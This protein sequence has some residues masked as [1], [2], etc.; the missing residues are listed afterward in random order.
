MKIWLLTSELPHEVTGGIA[1]YIDNYARLL[2]LSGHE[3]L[4]IAQSNEVKDIFMAPQVRLITLPKSAKY[5]AIMADEISF[6]YQFA[7]HIL[8]L[9]QTW[10]QPDIIES[11]EYLAL[12]YYL[13]QRKLTEST[14]LT[15]IPILLHLHT[16]YFIAAQ[17][18]QEP[19]YR[20]PYYWLG[21]MEKFC[22]QAADGLL[23]PSQF[24]ADSL[25]QI[26]EQPRPITVIPLPYSHDEKNVRIN[27]LNPD[28]H[29]GLTQQSAIL[30][31]QPANNCGLLPQICH[32]CESPNGYRLLYVG[33]LE[34]RKGIL[35]LL[36]ACDG[37]WADGA[38]FQLTLMGNDTPFQPKAMTVGD[39][40]R[41][42]YGR[43]LETGRLILAGAK[44]H[45]EVL[46]AMQQAWATIVP[47]LW[48][49]FPYTCLE[50]L[51]VGQVVLASRSGGQAEMIDQPCHNGF[52]FDW[53]I[54]GDFE[55][56]L[57]QILALSPPQREQICAQAQQ[58][59]QTMCA[60]SVIIP[61][62]LAHYQTLIDAAQ[63]RQTFPTVNKHPTPPIHNLAPSQ[64]RLLSV[65]IPFYNLAD[66]V[67]E[68]VISIINSDYQ[69][70]EIILVNDGSH[71]AQSITR[72]NQLASLGFAELQIIHT[73]NKG[74]A[75][76]RNVG[77]M[78]ARGEFLAF[79]D[80]D[81]LV[82]RD[83]FSRAIALLNQYQNI[84][85]V[86]SWVRHF[87]EVTGIWPTWNAEF[88][89]FLGHNMLAPL[90]V[91]RRAAYLAVGQNKASFAYNFEDYDSWL[92]LLEAGYV[93]VS[94][95]QPLVRY[96]VRAGSM[97]QSTNPHQLA[98]LHDLL[99]QHH[100]DL[101]HQWGA[102][103]FHLQNANGAAH[104]WVQPATPAPEL[105]SRELAAVIQRTPVKVISRQLP[106][107]KLMKILVAKVMNL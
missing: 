73:Q 16:P 68:T 11:Q 78:A 62:R 105:S 76:A 31:G 30:C 59:A 7:D 46:A 15:N 5:E 9:L 25:R 104:L 53:D 36:Q 96:R 42:K 58:R 66:Y 60:P 38:N 24:L 80:A 65:I 71:E 82:E 44:P 89:Y 48:E 29:V 51:A 22:L 61:Q 64:S 10:P 33:R 4:I 97:Y 12:P 92:S 52:L 49:N 54:T 102:E 75:T 43:W 86:Y 18:N 90:A 99:T 2:A 93:G 69:P 41:A 107:L 37:L 28:N 81:D 55:A 13:L 88:P 57:Q 98:Y 103:L 35:P 45:A 6:S 74:L 87:G 20:F 21:Q 91:V 23:A 83:F 47:S 8:H 85:F 77:A 72:L 19:R 84:G 56:K 3:V 70:R 67:A 14:P 101:Y 63:P 40:I 79:V 50:A 26:M 106:L 17:L 100:P 32:F 94:L 39:F 95:P 34:L 1:R 27:K